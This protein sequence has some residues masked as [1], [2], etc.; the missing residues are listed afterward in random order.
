MM[1]ILDGG[2]PENPNKKNLQSNT[3]TNS[4]LIPLMAPGRSRIWDTLMG[5]DHSDQC[6]I[7]A[8]HVMNT[9]P[10]HGIIVGPKFY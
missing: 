10:I 5:G 7:P 2:I 9:L 4:K 3:R 1:G 8:P 6:A